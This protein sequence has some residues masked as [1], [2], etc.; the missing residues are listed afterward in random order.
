MCHCLDNA[1][2]AWRSKKIPKDQFSKYLTL[3]RLSNGD[4]E[5]FDQFCKRLMNKA[6]HEF[7]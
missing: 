2:H 5:A 1:Y 4:V 7:R 3:S 6:I